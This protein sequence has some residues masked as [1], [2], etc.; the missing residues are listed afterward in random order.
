MMRTRAR[1]APSIP[2]SAALGAVLALLPAPALP[3]QPPPEPASPWT[4]APAAPPPPAAAGDV[5]RQTSPPPEGAVWGPVPR[6]PQAT[7]SD[8]PA[9]SPRAPGRGG[10]GRSVRKAAPHPTPAPTDADP[11]A[12]PARPGHGSPD[13]KDWPPLAR[14]TGPLFYPRAFAQPTLGEDLYGRVWLTDEGRL[15]RYDARVDGWQ[16]SDDGWR[17]QGATDRV[18][19]LSGDTA[20][21]VAVLPASRPDLSPTLQVRE[22]RLPRQDDQPIAPGRV[23]KA[24]AWQVASEAQIS[25]P[26]GEF[27]IRDAELDDSATG[28]DAAIWLVVSDR[29]DR[30]RLLR[31]PLV[32]ADVALSIGV[33]FP[34]PL[35]SVAVIRRVHGVPGGPLLVGTDRGLFVVEPARRWA[36]PRRLEETAG[37]AITALS[38]GTRAAGEVFAGTAGGELLR[39]ALAR[40]GAKVER[41]ARWSG[42]GAESPRPPEGSPAAAAPLPTFAP[43]IPSI[44]VVEVDPHGLVWFGPA[45]SRG[46]QAWTPGTGAVHPIPEAPSGAWI[47]SLYRDGAGR[48]WGVGVRTGQPERSMVR[49]PL[50]YRPVEAVAAAGV[51]VVPFG[52][53]VLIRLPGGGQ[54]LLTCTGGWCAPA[55]AGLLP[56]ELLEGPGRLPPID[57]WG[58]DVV[59]W[60]G[61]GLALWSRDPTGWQVRTWPYPKGFLPESPSLHAGPEAERGAAT[62]IVASPTGGE[63][64]HLVRT[65]EGAPQLTRA[66]KLHCP[67]NPSRTCLIEPMPDSRGGVR[68][69]GSDGVGLRWLAPLPTSDP[70]SLGW[71]IGSATRAPSGYP[72]WTPSPQPL[73]ELGRAARVLMTTSDGGVWFQLGDVVGRAGDALPGSTYARAGHGWRVSRALEDRLGQTWFRLVDAAGDSRWVLGPQMVVPGVLDLAGPLF[74]LSPG[75]VARTSVGHGL[76]RWEPRPAELL[77]SCGESPRRTT[78]MS[79]PIDVGW[80]VLSRCQVQTVAADGRVSD[81]L[82]DWRLHLSSPHMGFALLTVG[83]GWAVALR[84]RR[85]ERE[86]EGQVVDLQWQVDDLEERIQVMDTRYVIGMPLRD[87]AMF[88]GRR[89]QIAELLL[90]VRNR[91]VVT[92]SG[93]KRIGK[94]SLLFKLK[95]ILETPDVVATGADMPVYL[96]MEQCADG[97]HFFRQL[98]NKIATDIALPQEDRDSIGLDRVESEIAAR[99]VIVELFY[100]LQDRRKRRVLL[101]LDEAQR[102][103]HDLGDEGTRIAQ[104]CRHL[105]SEYP[106]VFGLIIAGVDLTRYGQ[107]QGPNS[108]LLGIGRILVLGPLDDA[109]A[110]ELVQKPSR[111]DGVNYDTSSVDLICLYTGCRPLRIQRLCSDIIAGWR[112]YCT[113][114]RIRPETPVPPSF[115]ERYFQEQYG[116]QSAR[117]DAA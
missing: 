84:G 12:T 44:R 99:D 51:E 1:A 82:V 52:R 26:D 36:A 87:D 83:L 49:F 30:G 98:L 43:G 35:T 77:Y 93:D 88:F 115:V 102:L 27:I 109:D 37:R 45:D 86:L 6:G 28:E 90:A 57:R 24:R 73:G 40:E 65:R 110:R 75:L 94:T 116:G 63:M 70:P 97:S 107:T 23:R 60:T 4:G 96:S 42:G 3:Q 76:D 95:R 92:I 13:R 50:D 31:V 61:H 54:D 29:E 106:D 21:E 59:A 5:W 100:L 56:P 9:A 79:L 10:R 48:M 55:P 11:S 104:G 67:S 15:Y 62:V 39:V 103:F 64:W 101:L 47:E 72:E 17:S 66:P 20:Y 108:D 8:G 33:K 91:A 114:T 112:R 25:L 80:R 71:R 18:M 89:H 19:R 78:S 81:P 32:G 38:A 46:L 34:D 105:A 14:E 117:L 16:L 69:A 111:A 22:L 113:E 53:D 58:D 68:L 74:S 85:R 7:P 2:L 41:V